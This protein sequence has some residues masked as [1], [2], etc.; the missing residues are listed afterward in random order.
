MLSNRVIEVVHRSK[1]LITN[2]LRSDLRER[3]FGKLD[4]LHVF[5][6]FQGLYLYDF[7]FLQVQVEARDADGL[8]NRRYILIEICDRDD[9]DP[10]FPRYD[11]GTV[12]D[13]H[14]YIESGRY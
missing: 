7:D 5:F 8:I 13:I 9:N 4:K 11:N 6:K 3:V 1:R 2:N 14:F 12:R 10:E